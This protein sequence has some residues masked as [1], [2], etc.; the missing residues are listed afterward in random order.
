MATYSFLSVQASIVGPGGAFSLGSGAGASEEGISIAYNEESNTMTTG[1]DGEVMHSLNATK[2]GKITVRLLKTSPTNQ[3]L[4][5]MFN[6]QRASPALHGQ[7]V[8]TIQDTNRGDLVVGREVAFSK[9]PDLN[10][11]KSAGVV[12]WVFDGGKID[13]LLGSGSAAA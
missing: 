2:S 9:G 13:E 1:A 8:I 6:L 11:G 12:E 7:N 5:L 3:K 4:S 10:Y